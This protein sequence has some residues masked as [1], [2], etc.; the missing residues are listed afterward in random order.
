MSS[1]TAGD[2]PYIIRSSNSLVDTTLCLASPIPVQCPLRCYDAP[3]CRRIS[4]HAS[5]QP[6]RVAVEPNP[7]AGKPS[8]PSVHPDVVS[9]S[10]ALGR[11][12]FRSMLAQRVCRSQSITSEIAVSCH[13]RASFSETGCPLTD[14]IG[15]C[16]RHNE[17]CSIGGRKI[18]YEHLPGGRWSGSLTG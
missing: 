15:R 12:A 9:P 1:P 18:Q 10:L 11:D 2:T 3:H 16:D 13:I 14:A 6:Y 8:A 7:R 5:A 4:C 17:G